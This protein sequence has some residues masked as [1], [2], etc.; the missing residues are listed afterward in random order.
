MLN[1]IVVLIRIKSQV[2]RIKSGILERATNADNFVKMSAGMTGTTDKALMALRKATSSANQPSVPSQVVRNYEN[3]KNNI[4]GAGGGGGVADPLDPSVK[5][6]EEEIEAL[7]KNINAADTSLL[8]LEH[9]EE[10][11]ERQQEAR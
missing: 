11:L 7:K 2:V 6:L 10:T 8:E 3:G 5:K 4:G 9:K 1:Y